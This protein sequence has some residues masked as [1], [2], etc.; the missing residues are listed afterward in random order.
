LLGLIT[1][2]LDLA[3]VESGRLNLAVAP[4][5][6]NILVD[7]C[8]NFITPLAAVRNVH[9]DCESVID[10]NIAVEADP[11]RLR[12]VLLN[13]LTNAVKY[14]R[15]NGEVRI[16][17]AELSTR[18]LR[19]AVTDTG[20]GIAAEKLPELF[21]PFSRLGRERTDDEGTGIGL[22]ISKQLVEMMGG[23]IGVHSTPGQGSTFWIQLRRCRL[24]SVAGAPSV[25]VLADD[26]V[27]PKQ[28]VVVLYIEDNVSN[29]KLVDSILRQRGNVRLLSATL[30]E[31]GLALAYDARPDIILVDINLP[32]ADGFYVLRELQRRGIDKQST[33]VA[34]SADATTETVQRG[35]AEGFFR[36]LTKPI[37]VVKLLEVIDLRLEETV[38]TAAKV[39]SSRDDCGA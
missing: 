13:L 26:D 11:M 38:V 31:S 12:Q 24:R 25:P 2:V 7:Q 17:I 33:I 28:S 8:V 21:L 6:L 5:R 32:D 27:T 16:S 37:D 23:K 35:L 39:T 1:D 18:S 14:N 9:V 19:L 3:R 10:A 30:A 15:E 20:A 22:A 4:L 34:V 36:Y 29:I